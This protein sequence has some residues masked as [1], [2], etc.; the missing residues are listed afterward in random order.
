MESLNDPWSSLFGIIRPPFPAPSLTN[1]QMF[2]S[3]VHCSLFLRTA[4]RP[5]IERLIYLHWTEPFLLPCI[6]PLQ[7]CPVCLCVCSSHSHSPTPTS[8]RQCCCLCYISLRLSVFSCASCLAAS[9]SV[10]LRQLFQSKLTQT[11]SLVPT[12]QGRTGFRGPKA[13]L[14]LYKMPSASLVTSNAVPSKPQRSPD[15]TRVQFIKC[16]QP[17][18]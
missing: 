15:L 2:L 14:L 11:G 5:L 13:A 18:E 4:P 1:T 10:L 9:E 16:R 7:S 12:A 6:H 8:F 3:F 17:H